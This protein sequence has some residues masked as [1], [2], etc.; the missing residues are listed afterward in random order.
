MP[1]GGK[2]TGSGR[3]P[4][5]PEE[6]RKRCTLRALPDEWDLI[7]RFAKII[8]YGDKAAAEKFVADYSTGSA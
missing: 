2:R 1:R 5:P 8:K 4:K 6:L 3:P 7:L